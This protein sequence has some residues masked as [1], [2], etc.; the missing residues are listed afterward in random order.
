ML[1]FEN[2]VSNIGDSYVKHQPTEFGQ[3]SSS[4]QVVAIWNYLTQSFRMWYCKP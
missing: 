1:N 2:G 3:N 4:V